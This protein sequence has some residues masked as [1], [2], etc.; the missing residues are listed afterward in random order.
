MRMA[1]PHNGV[2]HAR[3]FQLQAEQLGRNI[4]TGRIYIH[5]LHLPYHI[6]DSSLGEL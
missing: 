1:E 5:L 2:V 6:V 4:T 3:L